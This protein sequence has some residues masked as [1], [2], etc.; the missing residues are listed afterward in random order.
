MRL[1][2]TL[3]LILLIIIGCKTNIK[4]EFTLHG[5]II[6]D[7]PN[8]VFLEYGNV[9]DSSLVKDNT[10]FFKGE[11]NF[12]ISA[13]LVIHPISTINKA[14]YLE[15]KNIEIKIIV[16]EKKY[17]KLNVFF[18]KIDTIYGTKTAIL[19]SDFENF[20]RKHE[21]NT[22][23]N[24]KLFKKL[25]EII[26]Q[27]PRHRYSGDLL[28][29]ISNE[30]VLDKSQLLTLYKKLDT[31]KQSFISNANLRQK[32]YSSALL[33]VGEDIVDFELL[34]KNGKKIYTKNYRGSI[35]LIDFWASWC[36]PCRKQNPELLKI[37]DK[38]KKDDFQV[39]GVSI[40]R[41][42]EKWLRAIEKDKLTWENVI[43]SRGTESEILATYNSTSSVPHNFLI[44]QDGIIMA[45][46]ISMLELEKQLNQLK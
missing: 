39:L 32:I 35:L 22:D 23:W 33:K 4:K 1:K 7:S 13:N 36:S 19:E 21:P 28:S 3:I 17:K 30:S 27:N 37:Y 25:N 14:F 15:N 31:T 11:V 20:K 41:K 5:K 38:Y 24:E 26:E 43:D 6:G 45:I 9:K 44:N 40:D 12:P 8:Y 42:K 10:F 34:N 46:D 29:N 16:E 18:I 2:Y